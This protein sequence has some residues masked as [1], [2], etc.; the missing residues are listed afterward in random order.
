MTQE[1]I[2]LIVIGAVVAMLLLGGAGIGV[3]M[4]VRPKLLLRKRLRQIGVLEGGPQVQ[5]EKVDSRRQKRIQDKIKQLGQKS[6]KKGFMDGIYS[7]LLQAGVDISVQAYLV[8]CACIGVLSAFFYL[9]SGKPPLG[10]IPV[11]LIG[12][13]GLPKFVLSYMAN[14][15]KKK[16]TSHF[17]DAID[18]IVRGIRSGLPVNECF[19]IIAREFEAPL[20]EEFRLIVEGQRLGMTLD[21]ILRR[22]ISRLPTSE[23]KFFAIVTQI[24]KQTGGNLADTLSSLSSVLRER[25]RMRDKI[26]AYS[27]EA[28]ASAMII[29]SLPFAVAGLLSLVNPDYLMLLFTETKGNY[30]LAADAIWMGCG[31]G[32]MRG[33]INFEI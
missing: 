21:E 8:I 7:D 23:Y 6:E 30:V 9:M 4:I 20:G 3:T 2:I 33:M 5:N 14:K 12:A 31:I 15:R 11:L 13:F 26:Q 25:K 19:N 24:Q 16:F 10:A 17:A 18:T 29:G 28:K 32:V 22:G 1:T 27:S